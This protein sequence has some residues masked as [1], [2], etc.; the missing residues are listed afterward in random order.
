MTVTASAAVGVAVA[1][2]MLRG[3]EL[4]RTASADINVL[5]V[6]LVL[7]A[8]VLAG[9]RHTMR[10]PAELRAN[11]SLQL[12]WPGDDRPYLSGVKRAAL[13][14]LGLPLLVIL[15]PL[16]VLTLGPAIAAVHFLFG[17]LL[18]LI[19]LELL[20]M[21]LR[22]PPFASTYAPGRQ[23]EGGRGGARARRVRADQRTRVARTD[24]VS[25]CAEHWLC[26]SGD[27]C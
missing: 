13:A 11:W 14:G 6:Q 1:A 18:I 19:G 17:L 22:K 26:C 7:I 24:R 10:V 16:H 12:A 5:L 2:V 8:T 23:S 25:R 20:T 3:V 21:G 9:F 27:S 15:V 4:R